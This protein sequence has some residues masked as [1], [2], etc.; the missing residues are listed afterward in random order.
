MAAQVQNPRKAFLWSIQFIKHPLNPYLCQKVTLPE[1][2]V[3]QVTHGDINRDVKTAG[4]VTLG[5]LIVEKL[6]TT[7]GSDTWVWDWL[8]SCQDMMLG[9]GLIPTQYWETALV[10]ELAEDGT[11]IL[12]QYICNEVWPTKINGKALDRAQSENT[13]DTIEFSIGTMEK[14]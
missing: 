12:N 4:R 10:S 8:S 14:L 7:S 3:E 6:E 2:T 11:S 5:N 9:G 1:V 13:I